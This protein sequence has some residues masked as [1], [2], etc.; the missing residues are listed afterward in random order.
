[1]TLAGE[2]IYADTLASLTDAWSTWVP[3]YTGITSTGPTVTARYRQVGKTVE[4]EWQYVLG[5][6]PTI[7]AGPTFT[8]PVAMHS[9]YN[10]EA[11]LPFAGELRD[12]G[13]GAKP[14]HLVWSTST[15]VT[16]NYWSSTVA[17]SQVTSGNPHTWGAGD[18]FTVSGRYEAA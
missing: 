16:I 12:A 8:L 4:F 17:P 11:A 18:F 3:V 6:S 13:V 1:M 9:R 7:G 2:I 10:S 14:A 15:K 5:S